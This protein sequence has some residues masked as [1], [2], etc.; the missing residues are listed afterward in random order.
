MIHGIC[1]SYKTV[2]SIPISYLNQHHLYRSVT[3][4]TLPGQSDGSV[5]LSRLVGGEPGLI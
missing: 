5:R 2:P 1:Q 4:K 3:D